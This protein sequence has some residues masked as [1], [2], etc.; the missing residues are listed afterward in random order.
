[1]IQP[2]WPRC[3]LTGG[4]AE[5]EASNPEKPW[6][7]SELP[8]QTDGSAPGDDDDDDDDDDEDD[9]EDQLSD[10]DLDVQDLE[11]NNR[12]LLSN[13]ERMRT[14]LDRVVQVIIIIIIVSIVSLL[15][16]QER[17]LLRAKLQEYMRHHAECSAG[18]REPVDPASMCLTGGRREE[19][20]AGENLNKFLEQDSVEH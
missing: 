12:Q 11:V 7:R 17:N 19:G 13:T 10:D 16:F 15:N 3:P 4:E 1:M 2:R 6:L 9:D 14:E 18:R 8:Q 5:A 20:S